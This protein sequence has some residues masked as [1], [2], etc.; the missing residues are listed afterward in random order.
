MKSIKGTFSRTLL[1]G[2]FW[3]HRSSFRIIE[4]ERYLSNVVDYICW[5]YKKMNLPESCGEH[6]Y[7]FIDRDA[8]DTI[9]D[10]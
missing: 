4:T 1:K 3:Q 2:R 5:N 10:L 7:V 6:P 9:F 8:I